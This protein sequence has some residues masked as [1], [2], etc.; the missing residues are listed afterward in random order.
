MNRNREF[1]DLI[2]DIRSN[3][4]GGLDTSVRRAMARAKRR[5]RAVNLIRVP[6]AALLALV[7][8]F[9]LL[10]NTSAA[11]ARTMGEVPALKE[12]AMLVAQDPS[13]KAA[14]E[15]KYVQPIGQA[16][17]HGDVTVN[18]GYV[19]ADEQRLSVF[20]SIH[21]K[22]AP[23]KYRIGEAELLT[24]DGDP[25]FPAARWGGTAP[26]NEMQEIHFNSLE[27]NAL[28]ADLRLSLRIC[29]G[30]TGAP[31]WI[32]PENADPLNDT[33][34]D[35]YLSGTWDFELHL[36]PGLIAK[37]D[38]NP[39]GQWV[40]IGGQRLYLDSLIVYP[41][42]AKLIVRAD[43]D[44]T[45]VIPEMNFWLEDQNGEIWD[46]KRNGITETFEPGDIDTRILWM[47]SSY[48]SDAK[49]LLLHID[50][51]ALIPRDTQEVTVDYANGTVSPLPAYVE[52]VSMTPRD[53]GL[54]MEFVVDMGVKDAYFMPFGATYETHSGKKHIDKSVG[55]GLTEE[56]TASRVRFLIEDYDE[57][58]ILT[59]DHAPLT[60]IEPVVVGID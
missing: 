45:A 11:F 23:A 6:A 58:V 52:F 28:P 59:L 8:C 18:I 53:D 27:G 35:I 46:R 2:H 31:V 47:E 48:F 1:N 24:M 43:P 41:T 20:A 32:A 10:V 5:R 56:S 29:Y 44:N 49:S 22:G 3:A 17:T 9:T 19:I 33:H 54:E 25:L 12:L 37:G 51:A 42:Q 40:D 34:R 30:T 36:D 57:P 16:V 39:I 21:K 50:Q 38:I 14:V 60:D 4:P 55:H 13:L 26:M 15:N 7:L